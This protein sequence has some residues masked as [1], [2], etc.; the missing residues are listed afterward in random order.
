M[1]SCS[2]I[3]SPVDGARQSDSAI[4]PASALVSDVAEAT[5]VP[6]LRACSLA[7]HH[8]C[9]LHHL[10]HG[11]QRGPPSPTAA[12][13]GEL[14]ANYTIWMVHR[15]SWLSGAVTFGIQVNG[16]PAADFDLGSL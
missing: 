4:R 7:Q 8:A 9:T 5:A 16:N 14:L 6:M 1:S 11:I 13:K 3:Q 10:E 12:T 2:D 15:V